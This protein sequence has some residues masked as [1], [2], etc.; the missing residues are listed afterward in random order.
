MHF[1]FV[2]V[3]LSLLGGVQCVNFPWETIQLTEAD[4]KNFSAI[5]FGDRNIFD[6][7]SSPSTP[8]CKAYPDSSDWPIDS[9]WHQLNISLGGAL[10]KPTPPAAVCYPGPQYDVN[11]CL[12]LFR[13]AS[14]SRFYLDDPLTVLTQWPQGGTC[15]ATQHPTGNCT[16]VR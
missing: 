13:N 9:E 7:S 2:P 1:T 3:F 15:Y 4:V 10:L 12:Y 8:A 5:A 16:Q 14:M 6:S 11:K